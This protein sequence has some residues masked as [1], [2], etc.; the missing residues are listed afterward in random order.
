MAKDNPIQSAL[1]ALDVIKALNQQ[2]VT[3]LERL[4]QV[5]GLPKSTLVRLLETLIEAGYVFRV[6]RREGYALTEA[7]LRL[8]AGVRH[9]DLVVDV[10]RPLMEAFTR[11]HKWQVSLA[12]SESDVMLVR[13]TTRHISPF[14]REEIFLNR[15]VAMLR[16]AIGRAYFAFCSAEE[17]ELILGFLKASDPDQI[18]EIGSPERLKA[19][20]ASVRRDGY[21]T[22][23]RPA[24]DPTRSFAVP[25]MEPGASDRP[26]GSIVMFYYGSVMTEAQAVG[27]YLGLV[28]DMAAQVAA[29]LER[30]RSEVEALA[31]PAWPELKLVQ[32]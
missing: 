25:I 19:M 22:I 8:S 26:L 3:P 28:Q 5:T 23:V 32:G 14:S 20:T 7:V 24:L 31:P 9:R 1:R 4:H 17:Q 2:R 27:R 30:A 12:T 29:G 21:A 6:S 18:S 15:R 10:A 11:A 13:Y 16:S